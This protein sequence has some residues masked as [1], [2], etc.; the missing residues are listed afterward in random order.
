MFELLTSEGPLLSLLAFLLLLLGSSPSSLKSNSLS[1]P[2]SQLMAADAI[3]TVSVPSALADTKTD[4]IVNST[5]AF[6][7]GHFSIERDYRRPF[8]VGPFDPSTNSIK[9]TLIMPTDFDYS[10]F[11]ICTIKFPYTTNKFE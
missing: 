2:L 5:L 8:F 11:F 7:S 6:L 4:L 10:P 3:E 9:F 1:G